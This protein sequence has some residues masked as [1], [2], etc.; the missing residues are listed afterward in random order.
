MKKQAA[1]KKIFL[2]ARRKSELCLQCGKC[3]M[4]MTFFGGLLD[5][6][7]RD[8]IRWMELH[9]FMIEYAKKRGQTEYYYTIPRRCDALREL[10]TPDGKV[11]YAC[12]IYESRPQMCRDYDGSIA[13]PLGV[14]D[15]L[16]RIERERKPIPPPALVQ[17]KT[18][19]R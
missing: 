3:C 13:G 10:A 2:S 7:S 9:G 4:S 12:G 14:A 8:Q 1:K 19:T 11:Q 16:W 6:D 18:G 17:L 5:D 15:C